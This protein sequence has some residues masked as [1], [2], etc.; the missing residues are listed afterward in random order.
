[1]ISLPAAG[2]EAVIAF[3]P[4]F[5]KR[6]FILLQVLLTGAI[7]AIGSRTI[8]S[9]LRLCGLGSEKAFHKY[10][11]FLSRARWSGL[12]ASRILLSLVVKNFCRADEPLVFG[13]DETIE[14]RR[15]SKI[16]AKG[17]YRDPVRSS[18]SHF[19]KCSGLR[20]MCLMLLTEV[21]WANRI[22]ALP[23]F[24]ALAPSARYCKENKKRHKKITDWARQ[25]ILLLSRWLPGSKL[26]VTAESSYSALELLDAVKNKATV[27]TRLRLD[28]ALYQAA[29]S[30][31]AGQVGRKRLKG[32]RLPTLKQQLNSSE[33]VWHRFVIPQWYGQKNKQMEL[34]SDTAVW[35]HSAMEPVPVRWVLLRDPGSRGEPAALLSTDLGL[36][37]VTIVNHFIRRWTV[38]VTFKEVRTHLGVETQRQWSN[39]AIARTTPLLLALFSIT[40]LWAHELHKAGKLNKETTAWYQKKMPTFADALA[41]V[42]RQLWTQ[43]PFCTSALNSHISENNDPWICFLIETLARAA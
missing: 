5:S 15:G 20:W 35:Y 30:G 9:V 33:L 34:A 24:T 13:I 11:R 14:R 19:V 40:T 3:R 39:K 43:H 17:I 25:L 41:A 18:H 7:L 28:A 23:F 16:K 27:I 2:S 42:R 1:M 10:H 4:V 26:I 36:N 29:P 37:G 38:E 32:E 8:C 12:K 6:T 31:K 22:W 21:P